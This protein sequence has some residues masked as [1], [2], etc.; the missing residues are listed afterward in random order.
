M[1]SKK[2]HVV[3]TTNTSAEVKK[4]RG[5][6]SLNNSKSS[7][8]HEQPPYLLYKDPSTAM[9]YDEG[10]NSV[11]QLLRGRKNIAV[12][13]GAGISVSCGIPDFR[14]EGSGLYSTLDIQVCSTHFFMFIPSILIL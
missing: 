3:T 11:I 7:S 9:T 8:L 13:I 14:T 1:S 12:L 5:T 10:F 4:K 2:R 6:A